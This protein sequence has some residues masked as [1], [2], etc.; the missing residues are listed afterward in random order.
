MSDICKHSIF[1]LPLSLRIMLLFE[2]LF[3][4]IL[5]SS[6]LLF[7]LDP[8]YELLE[9]LKRETT[10]GNTLVWDDSTLHHIT[11]TIHTEQI[12]S[13]TQYCFCLLHHRLSTVDPHGV[14]LHMGMLIK[15][16]NSDK[17]LGGDSRE[18][19]NIS[20]C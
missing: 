7:S 9:C 11:Q 17:V 4:C 6:G 3:T 16:N 8:Y 15:K 10:P 13:Y 2:D 20:W 12:S 1:S 5:N 18:I 19:L 14:T